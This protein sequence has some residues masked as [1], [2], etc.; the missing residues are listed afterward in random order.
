M[1]SLYYQKN[2]HKQSYEIY[3]DKLQKYLP[4]TFNYSS[5]NKWFMVTLGNIDDIVNWKNISGQ[6]LIFRAPHLTNDN[7]QFVNHMLMIAD[8]VI[9]Q[10]NFM[11]Q[12][13]TTYFGML[14]VQNTVIHN[15]VHT[16]S[17]KFH[18][19]N[20]KILILGD[21]VYH[22]FV[23]PLQVNKQSSLMQVIEWLKGY[24]ITVAGAVGDLSFPDYVTVINGGTQFI[25]LNMIREN[26]GG[27]YL[28]TVLFDNCPNCL[29][30]SM[31]YGM[32]CIGFKSGGIPEILPSNLI[33]DFNEESLKATINEVNEYGFYGTHC[34]ALA[35]DIYNFDLYEKKIRD[36]IQLPL[37]DD[38]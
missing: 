17:K 5:K 37:C 31:A 18:H 1:I 7:R 29:L 33:C 4:N 19:H 8:K 32:P 12:V 27:I 16:N 3:Y 35:S 9:F 38:E 23:N 6:K 2:S 11:F 25:D 26:H 24:D 22:E 28:H 36:F 15:S 34:M 13:Y 10:S 14:D 21:F 20:N 30:E